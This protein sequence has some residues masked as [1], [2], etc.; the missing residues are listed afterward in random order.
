MLARI[1]AATISPSKSTQAHAV[2]RADVILPMQ[3][4]SSKNEAAKRNMIACR[5]RW[6]GSGRGVIVRWWDSIAEIGNV[7]TKVAR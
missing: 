6:C 3:K 4:R 2:N 7:S 1:T 5:L